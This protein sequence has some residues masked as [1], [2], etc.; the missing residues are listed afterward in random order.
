MVSLAARVLKTSKFYGRVFLPSILATTNSV[1]L[2]QHQIYQTKFAR[3]LLFFSRMDGA[4]KLCEPRLF[5]QCLRACLSSAGLSSQKHSTHSSRRGGATSA[6]SIDVSEGAL[7][8]QDHWKSQCSTLRIARDDARKFGAA[9]CKFRGN[10]S[11]AYFFSVFFFF[12]S[13]DPLRRLVFAHES[14][15][16][17]WVL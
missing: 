15:N 3:P 7:K 2:E 16:R 14:A 1:H 8:T 11:A 6:S 17:P 10:N 5:V 4:L 12:W 9:M 13:L